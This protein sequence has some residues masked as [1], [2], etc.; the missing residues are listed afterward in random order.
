MDIELHLIGLTNSYQ[1]LN[2]KYNVCKV[3]DVQY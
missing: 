1:N 2:D 3:K